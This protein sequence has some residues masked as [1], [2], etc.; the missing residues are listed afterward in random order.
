MAAFIKRISNAEILSC[1]SAA[2]F[3]VAFVFSVAAAS[4]ATVGVVGGGVGGVG[5]GG[6]NALPPLNQPTS[7]HWP[8]NY[9]MQ[10]STVIMPCNTSGPLDPQFFS[11]FGIVDVDWSN[12]KSV[13]VRPPPA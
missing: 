4:G 13:W 3:T 9:N 6:G 2:M 10:Q 1:C 11:Q 5:P 12:M 8:G 7:P